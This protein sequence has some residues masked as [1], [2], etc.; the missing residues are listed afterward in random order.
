MGATSFAPQALRRIVRHIDEMSSGPYRHDAT[1]A[2]R[3]GVLRRRAEA[4]VEAAAAELANA[5]GDRGASPELRALARAVRAGH[6]TWEQCV[7]G[8]ADD[9]PAVQAWHAATA[10]PA[11]A[12]DAADAG[13]AADAI[14]DDDYVDQSPLRRD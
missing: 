12:A 1:T 4:R 2:M 13:D 10:R 11:D 9:L 8:R 3:L 6:L 7:A 5:A 14:E